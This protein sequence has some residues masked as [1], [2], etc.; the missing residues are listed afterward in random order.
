MSEPI[1]FHAVVEQVNAGDDE[2]RVVLAVRDSPADIGAAVLMLGLKNRVLRVAVYWGPEDDPLEFRAAIPRIQSGVQFSAK[3][4]PVIRL[5]IPATD[6][7]SGMRLIKYTEEVI[8]FEIEDE[9]ERAKKARKARPKA[10]TPFGDLWQ[11]LLHRNMGFEYIPVVSAA[12][13]SVRS[14]GHEDPHRLMRKVFDVDS[15]ANLIGPDEIRARFPHTEVMGMVRE[16][17]AKVERQAKTPADDNGVTKSVYLDESDDFPPEWEPTY[18][19]NIYCD[20]S[21]QNT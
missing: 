21:Q 13:E 9:G 3:R 14:S 8:R 17:L 6:A 7:I 1:Q 20:T 18:D 4:P 12:L 11:E 16:A 5:D 10:K 15:L 2:I 19:P